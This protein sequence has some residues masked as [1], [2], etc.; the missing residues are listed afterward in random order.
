MLFG[1]IFVVTAIAGTA[2]WFLVGGASS[3]DH[4]VPAGGGSR[5][6]R[7]APRGPARFD[8]FDADALRRARKR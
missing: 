5:E 6:E 3:A 7:S 2:V 8:V 1:L 4:G